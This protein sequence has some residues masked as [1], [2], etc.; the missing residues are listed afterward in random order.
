M[1]RYFLLFVLS[2]LSTRTSGAV[3]SDWDSVTAPGTL[4]NSFDIALFPVPEINPSW[5]AVGS[6]ILAAALILRHSAKFRK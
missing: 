2:L 5:T 4:A 6:C 1:L 3:V